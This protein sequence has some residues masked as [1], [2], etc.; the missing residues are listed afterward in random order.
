C[1]L[2]KNRLLHSIGWGDDDDDDG[3]GGRLQMVGK[4]TK[5]MC[6]QYFQL[7]D[8]DWVLIFGPRMENGPNRTH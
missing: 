8:Q 3:G 4:E 1:N 5:T 2:A 6:R 7:F